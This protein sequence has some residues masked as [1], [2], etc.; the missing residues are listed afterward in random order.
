[1]LRSLRRS[2]AVKLPVEL[3]IVGRVYM[4]AFRFRPDFSREAAQECS[5]QRK[6][7]VIKCN[8]NQAPKG[9]KNSLTSAT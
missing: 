8:N 1:M 7:W 9:R 4:T 2:E 6:P 3:L 5:P